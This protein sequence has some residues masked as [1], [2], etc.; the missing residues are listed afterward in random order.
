MDV[1]RRME[2]GREKNR[3]VKG[4]LDRIVRSERE[5]ARASVHKVELR[6]KLQR[7]APISPKRLRLNTGSY[8]TL[9][10]EEGDKT[11]TYPELVSFSNKHLSENNIQTL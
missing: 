1:C 2:R 4:I 7:F 10:G 5:H 3:G 6:T 11:G 8:E 9:N